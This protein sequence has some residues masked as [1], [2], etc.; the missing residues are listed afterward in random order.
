MP[1][2]LRPVKISSFALVL[3]TM[4]GRSCVPPALLEVRHLSVHRSSTAFNHNLREGGWDKDCAPRYD[5][6][7]CLWEGKLSLS[8][9]ISDKATVSPAPNTAPGNR[10]IMSGVKGVYVTD[11]RPAGRRQ[12]PTLRPLPTQ[13]RPPLQ[14]L[15]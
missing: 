5:T 10:G 9:C 15:A 3:P 8:P 13:T 4:R 2:T 11:R 7:P 6:E 1:L 12:V 14:Q